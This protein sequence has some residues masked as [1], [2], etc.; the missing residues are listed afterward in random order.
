MS[1]Y[2]N[3]TNPYGDIWICEN[4]LND[5]ERNTLFNFAK[6]STED[7]WNLRYIKDRSLEASYKYELG[8][9]EWKETVEHRNN[10][11]DDK[12]I[13]IPKEYKNITDNI[14]NKTN[15]FFKGQYKI[16]EYMTIQRQ[17]TGEELKVH[18]DRG[19]KTTLERAI[20]IYL[21]EDYNGGE[22][23][24]PQHDV[25]YK[26]KAGSLISFPGTDEYLHGV[27]AVADGPTRFALSNFCYSK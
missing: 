15:L 26:P 9:D 23:W 16:T 24:F 12:I 4:F 11:W 21:N 18:D 6:N 1:D 14:W 5:E 3:I 19:Y 17:Y 20:V 13:E 7:E 22:I 25:S 27:K 8:S 2:V 10:F